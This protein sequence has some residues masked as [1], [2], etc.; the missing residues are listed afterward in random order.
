MRGVLVSTWKSDKEDRYLYNFS[1]ET[2][3]LENCHFED[4]VNVKW[5]EMIVS[6]DEVCIVSAMFTFQVV[7]LLIVYR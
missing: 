6:S 1:G 3:L 7:Q 2:A 5:V 4:W